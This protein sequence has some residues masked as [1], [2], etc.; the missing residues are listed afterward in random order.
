MNR[1]A[2]AFRPDGA[3]SVVT[4]ADMSL[5]GVRLHGTAFED[6]DEFRLV[7]PRRGDVDAR[8][9]WSSQGNVGARFDENLL[10]ADGVAARENYAIRRFRS[11]NYGSGRAFGKRG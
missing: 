7:I 1:L 2:L 5:S 3:R 8:V 9:R 10:L 11:Y 4:V 6:N